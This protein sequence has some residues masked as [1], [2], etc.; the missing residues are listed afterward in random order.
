ML[1][2]TL[3]VSRHGVAAADAAD[4]AKPMLSRAHTHNQQAT[5]VVTTVEIK[6]QPCRMCVLLLVFAQRVLTGEND[7][8]ATSA[9]NLR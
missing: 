2:F 6:I 4:A 1:V 3:S 7:P 8:G 5:R 9:Q